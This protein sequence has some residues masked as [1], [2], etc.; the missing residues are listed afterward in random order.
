MMDSDNHERIPT[1]MRLLEGASHVARWGHSLRVLVLA[2]GIRLKIT[3]GH[4]DAN[5]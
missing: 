3:V 1:P 5:S 4:L 2:M